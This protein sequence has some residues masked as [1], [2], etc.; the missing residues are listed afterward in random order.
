[1]GYRWYLNAPYN[2]WEER[3]NENYSS[4]T[5]FH[6]SIFRLLYSPPEQTATAQKRAKKGMQLNTYK[7][8]IYKVAFS[9]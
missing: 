9:A 1:L 2:G 8:V 3:K 4:M 5:I 7:A 6:R